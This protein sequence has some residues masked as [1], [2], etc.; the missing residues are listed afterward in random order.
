MKKILA[1]L[2]AI[3]MLASALSI[4]SFTAF[5][6]N[7]PA[8][9]TVLRISAV[10]SDGKT[11]IVVKDHTNFETGWNEAITLVSPKSMKENKY[12]RI[13]VDFYAD[14]KANADGEF[15]SGA[16]FSFSTLSIPDDASITLN[17]N[18]HK[19]DRDLKEWE[20]DGEVLYINEGANVTINDGTITGG[21][22]CNG[23]GSIHVDDNG[24]LVLNNVHLVDNKVVDD[25]GSAIAAYNNSTVTMNG[26]SISNN[27]MH[28]SHSYYNTNPYGTIYLSDSK[29]VLTEVEIANN[30]ATGLFWAEGLVVYLNDSE[31]TMKNC[32]V[33]NNGCL[34]TDKDPATGKVVDAEIP[35]SLFCISDSDSTLN[36]IGCKFENNGDEKKD[37]TGTIDRNYDIFNIDGGRLV[38]TDSSFESNKLNHII[39]AGGGAF[40][41][42][43]SRFINNRARIFYNRVD[44][45]YFEKCTFSGNNLKGK[46][47]VYVKYRIHSKGI[48]FSDCDFINNPLTD[49]EHKKSVIL[50]TETSN[51]T[52]SIFGEGSLAMII[53]L[54]A[55]I[56]STVS[57]CLTIVYNKKKA[58]PT[59]VNNTKAT[60]TQDEE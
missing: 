53:S 14:W 25:D 4:V 35:S 55:L 32:V 31:A 38:V 8:P 29:A 23:A 18:G 58:A 56:T 45:G 57:I 48:Q 54:L 27:R 30:D 60:K 11:T 50:D 43:N 1:T 28:L 10:K 37:L 5:A 6:E 39:F 16:G 46:S 22:S 47:G 59:A 9:G 3:F 24:T 52:G 7:E 40:E 17:L 19:I 12:T 21:W 44:S 2:M 13:I 15:G 41:V 42:E 34:P 33:K 20:Y 26:G 51:G 36:V 49:E